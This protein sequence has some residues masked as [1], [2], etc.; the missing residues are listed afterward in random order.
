M[1]E[2]RIIGFRQ[3]GDQEW[4][5]DLE[6][7]H[8]QHIRHAPPWQ[9]RPWVMTAEGRAGRIGSRLP[10]R[11]CD[12]SEVGVTADPVEIAE[13]VRRALIERAL[14]AYDDAALQGLCCE[15][16]WEAAVAAMRRFDVAHMLPRGQS[17]RMPGGDPPPG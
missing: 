4:V 7:G 14:A 17:P 2:R 1:S 5:A 13:Q 10:C 16:A 3:D 11:R 8:A 12:A 6:C 9:V 15:G